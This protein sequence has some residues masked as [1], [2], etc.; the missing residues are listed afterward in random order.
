MVHVLLF[1]FLAFEDHV[2]IY[3]CQKHRWNWKFFDMS[4]CQGSSAKSPHM[5]LFLDV[6]P[7][8]LPGLTF[9]FAIG[10]QPKHAVY[11]KISQSTYSRRGKQETHGLV[12]KQSV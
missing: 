3:Y 2:H 6:H 8:S 7:S 9:D 11:T 1:F 5:F 10:L 12:L 4:L